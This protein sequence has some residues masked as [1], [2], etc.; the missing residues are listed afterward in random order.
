[1]T[2][3]N[4]RFDTENAPRG[5]MI[6]TPGPKG[7]VRQVFKPDPVIIACSDGVTVTLSRWIPSEERWNMIGKKE[8]IVAWMPWPSYP[9]GVS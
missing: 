3:D 5:K 2:D 9:E 6:E 4:W 7:S 8:H 1:M